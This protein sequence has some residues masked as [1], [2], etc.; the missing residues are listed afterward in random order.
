MLDLHGNASG[1]SDDGRNAGHP[2]G[3]HGWHYDRSHALQFANCARDGVLT[4]VERPV[5][6]TR[7]PQGCLILATSHVNDVAATSP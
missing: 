4:A 2:R 7:L 1:H 6:L 3:F 5:M